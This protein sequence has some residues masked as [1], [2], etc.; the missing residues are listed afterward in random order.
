MQKHTPDDIARFVAGRLLDNTGT[1]GLPWQEHPAAVPEHALTGQPFTGINVLLLWQAAKRYSLN[2]HRWL[3]GDDLRQ[4]GGTV[5]P[6][7][8]PMTLVR[9]RPALSLMKVINL[10]Q[11]E[12]LPD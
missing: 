10:A 1:T 2:S 7:Q 11:C 3:T 4:A 8:R 5:I 6:G 9:Y 12:G